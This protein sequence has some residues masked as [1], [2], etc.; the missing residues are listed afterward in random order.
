VLAF[1]HTSRD[2]PIVGLWNYVTPPRE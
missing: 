1:E 2:E